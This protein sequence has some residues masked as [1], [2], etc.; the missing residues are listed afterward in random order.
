MK[1]AFN[2]LLFLSVALLLQLGSY[3]HAHTDVSVADANEMI[4]TNDD[5][6][7]VD[8]R[9]YQSE[10]CNSG[11]IPGAVNHTWNGSVVLG[12]EEL[13]IDA[14]LLVVCASGFRSNLASNFLDSQGYLYV[15]DMLGGMSSWPY[16]KVGC[17]D[18]DADSVNDDLD[19]C[20][21]DYNPSQADSDGDALGNACDAD[22]PNLDGLNPVDFIDFSI[23]ALNWLDSAP[24][25]PGDIDAD[26]TVDPNDLEILA[27]YWLADCYEI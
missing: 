19:N 4:D 18:T 21:G 20:P 15:Y 10:Y 6:I 3:T 7:V 26:G 25:L 12:Y 24:A 16:E 27:D 2:C 5:L 1:K 9:A 22:C 14:E 23:L 17:V 13:P 8:V 11:H